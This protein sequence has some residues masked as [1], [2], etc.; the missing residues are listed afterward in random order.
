[1]AL[2]NK[3][4]NVANIIYDGET[5]V[6]NTVETLLALNPLVVKAVDLLTAKIGDLLT[7]TVTITN[8][9]L[10]S[11]NNVLFNDVLPEGCTYVPNSFRVDGVSVTPII[12]ANDIEYTFAQ[13]T[14]L[15][16]AIVTFQVEVIGGD[17]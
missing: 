14:T 11:I 2:I 4:E 15:Q 7:Y 10:T 13:L 6:S 3:L 5:I 1:M 16:V 8:P 12:S 9:N 17:I